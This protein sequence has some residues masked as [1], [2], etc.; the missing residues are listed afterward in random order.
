MPEAKR[1][2]PLTY[3][4]RVELLP[5]IDIKDDDG[6][7]VTQRAA[8]VTDKQVDD[9]LQ[10]RRVKTTPR[11]CRSKVARWRVPTTRSRLFS[12]AAWDT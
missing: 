2:Q 1:N 9:A 12:T 4:A 7:E 6:I 10:Q 11:W 3:T 8:K 5:Q